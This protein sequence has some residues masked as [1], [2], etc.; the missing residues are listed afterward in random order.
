MEDKADNGYRR[1]IRAQ[2][3]V[4]GMSAGKWKMRVDEEWTGVGGKGGE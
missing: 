4:E 1:E 3:R 2:E